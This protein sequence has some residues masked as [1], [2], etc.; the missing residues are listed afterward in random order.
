MI[1]CRNKPAASLLQRTRHLVYLVFFVAVWLAVPGTHLVMDEGYRLMQTCSLNKSVSFP[2]YI[3]YPGAELLGTSL[4]EEVRPLPA[5]Y[6]SFTEN[7]LTCLYS[8]ALALVSSCFHQGYFSLFPLLSGYFL[9]LFVSK[10]LQQAGFSRLSAELIPL[11]GTPLLFYSLGFW[12]YPLCIL[13]VFLAVKTAENSRPVIAYLLIALAALFRIDYSIAFLLVM[14]RLNC[15]WIKRLLYALPALVIL[16]A[17]NWVLSGGEYLGTHVLASAGEQTLYGN[18]NMPLLI[19]KLSAAGKAFFPMLPGKTGTAWFIP[20]VMLWLVWGL[21][22]REDKLGSIATCTGLA[23]CLSAVVVWAVNGFAFLD[24]FSMKHPLMVFPVLWLLSVDTVRK[25]WRELVVLALLV[26]LLL[27]MH[28]D[29]P[30]WGIRH[31]FLPLFLMMW[32]MKPQK[33]KVLPVVSFGILITGSA[34]LF[35][36]INRSRVENI[37]TLSE[38]SGNAVITTNWI[39][40]G[41]LTD[42]MSNNTPV[43]YT[44]TGYQLA[45]SM[46]LLKNN[47]PVVVCL[48]R[49]AANT[50]LILEELGYTCS[51]KGE[52]AF[53]SSLGCVFIVP[54]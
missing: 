14:L 1:T 7:G 10:K 33:R 25:S 20:G 38:A 35:L 37:S 27:P 13:L 47:N 50:V 18:T 49:D 3:S 39:I 43:V 11:A 24:G 34:L 15:S 8:P 4:A 16:F 12:S 41:W 5:H 26:L 28:T 40:P 46:L 17:G 30:E 2:V 48:H 6:G 29:G 31:T 36:G 45:E 23:L 22:F 52:V 42:N 53:G 51:V 21:A 54:E 19:Q 32:N 44:S 9:W